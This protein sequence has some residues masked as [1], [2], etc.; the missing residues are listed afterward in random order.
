MRVL[1][2]LFALISLPALAADYSPW[3]E[4]DEPSATEQLLAQAATPSPQAPQTL[5]QTLP[6]GPPPP[7]TPPYQDPSKPV[8]PKRHPGD[9]C[10]R[11]CRPNEVA[12]GGECIPAMKN[13][14]KN[15]CSKG[16]TGCAC[17]NSNSP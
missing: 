3:P 6:Q 8:I 9:Y 2:L 15:L 14:K 10:C 16:G 11:H 5:P 4:R 17:G 7:L 1:A 13:G 12:C